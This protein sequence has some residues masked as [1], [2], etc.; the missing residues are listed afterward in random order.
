M[1]FGGAAARRYGAPT[2]LLRS[3]EKAFPPRVRRPPVPH[4]SSPHQ[5]HG[6]TS[7]DASSRLG[8]GG[9]WL[10]KHGVN[11]SIHGQGRATPAK[12]RAPAFA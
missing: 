6:R 11:M 10:G 2:L 8:G 7:G 9:L 1:S 12:P 4:P 5:A 3:L